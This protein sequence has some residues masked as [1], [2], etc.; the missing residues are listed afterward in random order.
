MKVSLKAAIVSS[1]ELF[2][3]PNSIVMLDLLNKLINLNP[4][5]VSIRLHHRIYISRGLILDNLIWLLKVHER[6]DLTAL[7]TFFP[8]ISFNNDFLMIKFKNFLVDLLPRLG[9]H[10]KFHVLDPLFT[11]LS[12]VLLSVIHHPLVISLSC[13]HF[14]VINMLQLI[15]FIRCVIA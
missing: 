1:V 7:C 13:L 5:H 9:Y 12:R 15:H 8:L 6:V 4:L 2:Y 11:R 10:F 3:L 14:V